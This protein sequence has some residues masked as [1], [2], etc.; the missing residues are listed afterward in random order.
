MAWHQV[1]HHKTALITGASSGIGEACA[2]LL[3]AENVNLILTARREARLVALQKALTDQYPITCDIYVNDV[4][5]PET[6]GDFTQVLA[7][8]PIDILIN[9][10]G[11]ALGADK[12]QQGN[13]EEWDQ[14]LD[15]NVKGLLYMTRHV[16]PH[17]LSQNTGHIVNLG[18]IAGHGVYPGGAVYCA[19]KHAVDAI[20]KALRFDILG[21][22]IRVTE[23]SPGMVETEFS[24][25]RFRGQEDTA[26]TVYSGV[27][28]LS[29]EDI[30]H[31]I[32]YA[33]CAPPHVNI[34]EI[35]VCP[36]DQA[37]IGTAGVHRRA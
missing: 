16:L 4:A 28:A 29:A 1:L 22:P 31:I 6:W 5:K 19:S 25:V 30:A 32:L 7:E 23:I 24:V 8:A 9:N 36:T 34:S 11:L 15:T 33:L 10:A 2:Y 18:S 37:G 21:T 27:Q 26:K 13:P 20:S 14:M 3:A 35:I 17:M 12:L